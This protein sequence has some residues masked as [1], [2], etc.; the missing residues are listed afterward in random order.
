MTRVRVA[1]VIAACLVVQSIHAGIAHAATTAGAVSARGVQIDAREAGA[2]CDGA[3]DDAPALAA[4]AAAAAGRAL[5]L[6]ACASPYRVANPLSLN[7]VTLVF[8]PG[9]VIRPAAGT[10]VAINGGVVAGLHRIFDTSEKGAVI[11][12]DP[13]LDAVRPEWWHDGSGN[14]APAINAAVAFA[15][16]TTATRAKRVQLSCNLYSIAAEITFRVQAPATRHPVTFAGGGAS[17]EGAC[18]RIRATGPLKRMLHLP[19]VGGTNAYYRFENFA[20]EGA[21][22]A[23]NGF[24]AQDLSYSS[25]VGLSISGTT[26]K[27]LLIHVPEM[28]TIERLTAVG[29]ADV[30]WLGG[31]GR[32]ANAVHLTHSTIS[33]NSGIAFYAFALVG[34]HMSGNTIQSNAKAAIY[35]QGAFGAHITG[36][37]IEGNGSAGIALSPLRAVKHYDVWLASREAGGIGHLGTAEPCRNITISTN[38]F[39]PS[40]QT[41]SHIFAAAVTG[42]VIEN[43]RARDPLLFTAV[44]DNAYGIQRDV[45]VRN[46][47]FAAPAE[48][49]TDTTQVAYTAIAADV[50]AFRRA[51]GLHTIEIQQ[52]PATNY[53]DRDR[54]SWTV[55][56]GT[57][58][59]VTPG[60]LF[61]RGKSSTAVVASDGVAAAR[62]VTIDLRRS[63]ELR[64]RWIWCGAWLNTQGAGDFDADIYLASAGGTARGGYRHDPRTDRAVR[65]TGWHYVAT[66]LF[67]DPAATHV[68]CGFAPRRTGASAS[69]TAFTLHVAD[70]TLSVVGSPFW[71]H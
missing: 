36:N 49:D 71:R 4:A 65:Q 35:L 16:Q 9:A 13:A 17:H 24:E 28:V 53:F 45:A 56:Q 29:N 31:A 55:V 40:A 7:N 38:I 47:S 48:A 54:A 6:R 39:S 70:P 3:S 19:A 43:N 42:L 2:K 37:Y 66:S 1:L 23:V 18:T 46:Q 20:L 22:K 63:P 5:Y 14:W 60:A 25:L 8:E 61:Y 64:G 33:H 32:S 21:A 10:A 58:G 68:S 27:A 12:G 15:Q 44:A 69:R 67:V 59:A 26:G 30:I 52:H 62:G 50:P 11:T 57:G 41:T 51:R 34:L